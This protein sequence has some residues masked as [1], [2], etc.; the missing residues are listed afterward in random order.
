MNP[1]TESERTFVL[2]ARVARMATLDA[3]GVP[4]VL[5]ICYTL[6]DSYVWTPLDEKSK[7]VPPEQLNRVQNIQRTPRVGL[8]VDRYREDWSLL[9]WVQIRGRGELVRSHSVNHKDAARA[10]H[11]KYSQ[12]ESHDLAHR[13]MIRVEVRQV[14]SWGCL[15]PEL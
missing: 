5:P 7:T 12:Y 1:F 9:G 8:V 15:E 10:L 6:R 13:P 11:D 14:L 2:R 3:S 4:R